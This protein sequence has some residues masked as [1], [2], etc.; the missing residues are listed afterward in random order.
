MWQ[1]KSQT[2]A[3]VAFA[4]SSCAGFSSS[5]ALTCWARTPRCSTWRRQVSPPRMPPPPVGVA[6]GRPTTITPQTPRRHRPRHHPRHCHTLTT[7]L[8]AI[9]TAAPSPQA[10]IFSSVAAVG[11]CWRTDDSILVEP[12]CGRSAHAVQ[13]MQL[14]QDEAIGNPTLLFLVLHCFQKV[15]QAALLEAVQGWDSNGRA[16]CALRPV[17]QLCEYLC[18]RRR[19]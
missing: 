10:P 19:Y 12:Y 2:T 6:G 15:Q 1:V 3:Q 16:P 11:A 14:Q 17:I 5:C 18:K 4:E 9:P 7:G 13:R 8:L